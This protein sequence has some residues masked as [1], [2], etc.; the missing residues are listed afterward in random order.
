MLKKHARDVF[1]LIEEEQPHIKNWSDLGPVEQLY[2]ALVLEEKAATVSNIEIFRCEDQW[3]A[4][5]MLEQ[6]FKGKK[7]NHKEKKFE[8]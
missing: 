3:C 5:R 2:Y 4:K 8:E 7:Q 1:N 6:A